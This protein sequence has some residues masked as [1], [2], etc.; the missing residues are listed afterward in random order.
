MHIT[1][2]G[3]VENIPRVLPFGVSAKVTLGSWPTPPL[4]Q[5]VEQLTSLE[6]DELYR[7]LNM[8]IGM[9]LIVSATD[10]SAVQKLIPEDSWIIGE[11]CASV[12]DSD[13]V[14]LL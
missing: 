4:F 9:V 5:L 1:G 2:G 6:T 12:S 11:L 13:E 14:V 8:G 10:A 3:L 7:T